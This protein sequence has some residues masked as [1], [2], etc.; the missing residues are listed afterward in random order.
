MYETWLYNY[1][2]ETKQQSMEWQHSDLPRP[3][4][5]RVQKSAG[6]FIVSSFWDKDGVLFIDYLQSAKLSTR[7]IT[8]L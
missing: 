3:Q 7:S 5:F 2:P 4:K 6:K 1:D 8:Y